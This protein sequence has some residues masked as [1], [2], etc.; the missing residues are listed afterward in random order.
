[1]IEEMKSLIK[2]YGE[3]LDD[4]TVFR[5]IPG[6]YAEITTPFLDRHNDYIQIYVQKEGDNYVLTDGGNTIQDLELSGFPLDSE[7]RQNLLKMTLA[8]LGVEKKDPDELVVRATWN[9]FPLRKD[10][11]I[12]AIIVVN[13]LCYLA[14]LMTYKK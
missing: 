7:K 13:G 5:E 8:G 10:N 3:W 9:N 2:E 6:G 11:L 4:K 14:N 12:Q 1:M